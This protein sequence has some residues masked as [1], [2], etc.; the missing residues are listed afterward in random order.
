MNNFGAQ[1]MVSHLKKVLMKKPQNFM[2]K[3]DSQ[4][5]NY[6]SPLDQ[7]IINENYNDFYKIIKN[8]GTEIVNLKLRSE[9]EEFCDSIFTVVVLL[10]EVVFLSTIVSQGE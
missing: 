5:W 9:N 4:K 2:S 3:V 6:T 1:N 8:S 7:D 10:C